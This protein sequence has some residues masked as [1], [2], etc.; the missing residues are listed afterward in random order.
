M[1]K[2][3]IRDGVVVNIIIVDPNSVPEWCADWPN[4]NADVS[5]G[6]LWDGSS[7]SPPPVD[8]DAVA[9]EVRK[10][11]TSLLETVVDPLAGNI[12]RWQ[13]LQPTKQNELIAYRRLLLDIP[14]QA[15]FPL[16]VEWPVQPV[17]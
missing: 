2:A 3:E 10:Q 16:S 9:A 4:T 13:E 1:N 5:I 12:L 11:R 15:G 14:S 17:I 8:I 7:F 6:H